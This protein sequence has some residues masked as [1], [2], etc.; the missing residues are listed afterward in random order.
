MEFLIGIISVCVITI[1]VMSWP[2][3]IL[4]FRKKKN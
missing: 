3:I 1:I 2:D 4:F